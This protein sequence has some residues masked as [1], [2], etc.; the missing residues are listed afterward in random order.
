[1][2]NLII[3][4]Q[5]QPIVVLAELQAPF[6]DHEA[7]LKVL[8]DLGEQTLSMFLK[9]LVTPD[10]RFLVHL[11]ISWFAAFL[12]F[13]GNVFNVC[14]SL[15]RKTCEQVLTTVIQILSI[16][17]CRPKFI[18]FLLPITNA[19]L[20]DTVHHGFQEFSNCEMSSFITTCRW[21]RLFLQEAT[22][23]TESIHSLFQ[24]AAYLI[25]V[26]FP[27]LILP[28]LVVLTFSI[29]FP[30]VRRTQDFFGETSMSRQNPQRHDAYFHQRHRRFN[31]LVESVKIG[32]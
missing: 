3:V 13:P 24:K 18:G 10:Q 7:Y 4:N 9:T 16:R 28:L 27:D 6:E 5:V 14:E 15:G 29:E 11:I 1:M 2:K 19:D 26:L 12:L 17:E 31:R 21:W 30:V 25:P 23:G 8:G 22:N 20:R 32:S